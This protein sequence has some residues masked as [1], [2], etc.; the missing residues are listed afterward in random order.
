MEKGTYNACSCGSEILIMIGE[1][2][3]KVLVV[4]ATMSLYD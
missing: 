1:R 3:G 2:K 4:D